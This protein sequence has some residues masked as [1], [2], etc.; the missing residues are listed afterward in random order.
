MLFLAPFGD[1]YSYPVPPYSPLPK[2]LPSSGVIVLVTR[3]GAPRTEVAMVTAELRLQPSCCGLC[4]PSAR[5]LPVSPSPNHISLLHFAGS[6]CTPLDVSLWLYTFLHTRFLLVQTQTHPTYTQS[7]HTRSPTC[8]PDM[9]A[10]LNQNIQTY[11]LPP[12]CSWAHTQRAA[13]VHGILACTHDSTATPT[14]AGDFF[15]FVSLLRSSFLLP[16]SLCGWVCY[17]Y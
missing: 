2:P 6:A 12:P 4:A 1:P 5:L 10:S 17:T 16:P 3:G 9:Y 7:Q 8:R 15:R 13:S 14:S 11:S